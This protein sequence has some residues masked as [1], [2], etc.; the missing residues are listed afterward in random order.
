MHAVA[1]VVPPKGDEEMAQFTSVTPTATYD[2]TSQQVNLRVDACGELKAPGIE[3]DEI[4][5]RPDCYRQGTVLCVLVKPRARLKVGE[6][7]KDEKQEWFENG[8]YDRAAD[9]VVLQAADGY[10]LAVGKVER[11]GSPG[12]SVGVKVEKAE[13]VKPP[14][15]V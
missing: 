9:Y 7:E 5:R 10:V 8:T 4:K 15:T 14:A 11:V 12:G 6:S 2:P 13:P 1:Q 3:L